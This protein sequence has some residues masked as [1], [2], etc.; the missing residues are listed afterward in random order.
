[1]GDTSIDAKSKIEISGQSTKVTS[2]SDIEMSGMD[3]VVK[4]Q[5]TIVSGASHKIEIV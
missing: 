1:M 2:A 4:G 3:T 5:T